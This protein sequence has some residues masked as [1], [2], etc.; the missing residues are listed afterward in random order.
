MLVCLMKVSKSTT[1]PPR[2][3]YLDG[4]KYIA[5]LQKHILRIFIQTSKIPFIIFFP[6]YLFFSHFFFI[7]PFPLCYLFISPFSSLFPYFSIENKYA[8]FELTMIFLFTSK[9]DIKFNSSNI[10][11]DTLPYCMSRK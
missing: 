1:L 5:T 10:D 8:D 4:Y 2:R 6:L 7:P 3:R 9:L 11:L